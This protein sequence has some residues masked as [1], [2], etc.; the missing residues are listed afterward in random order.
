MAPIS[1]LQAGKAGEYLVCADLI[2]SGHVAFPSEQGL[3]FD[4]VVEVG[5]RL[6]RIQVKTTR[7][8]RAIPQRKQHTPGYLFN[9]KRCGK[10]GRGAYANGAVDLFALV[11]LDTREIGYLPTGSVKR[12]MVFRSPLLEGEYADER[13][14][15]RALS[16]KALRAEGL[17][18]REIGRRAGCDAS[19]AQRIVSGKNGGERAHRYLRSFTF[20][21]A[22]KGITVP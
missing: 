11:A 2:L 10:G 16:I 8:P 14:G 15:A 1:D 5:A 19:F 6:L 7:G 22:I 12:T 4:V 20:E 18:Y 9:V 3:P 17:S 13:A 21:A